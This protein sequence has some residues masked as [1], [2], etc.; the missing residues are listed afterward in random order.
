MHHIISDGWSINIFVNEFVAFY[1]ALRNGDAP[2]LA[3]LPIQYADYTNWQRE[4]LRDGEIDRQLDYWRRK[5]SG[6]LQMVEL[7]ADYPRTGEPALRG[8]RLTQTLSPELSQSLRD[9]SRR[10]GV[11]LYMTLLAAFNTLL[12]RSTN[13]HDVIVGTA[14]AG[15]NRAEIENLI[16]IFINMLVLRTDLSG[17]PTFLELLTRVRNVTVEAYAHQNVPF[18]RLV[19]ALQPA[20]VLSRSPFFQIAFGVDYQ[21]VRK[22]TLPDL[23]LSPISFPTELSR[24]DLTLWVFESDAD[25]TASWTFNTDLFTPETIAR[26]QARFETLLSSIVKEPETRLLALEIFSDDEKQQAENR[27][28]EWEESNVRKLMS[29]KRRPVKTFAGSAS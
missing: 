3:T 22:F 11:T 20:R 24:Y 13:Q 14:V 2:N 18:E 21:P 29:V 1:K 25:L 19:E 27:Q 5:L 4:R 28:Q 6:P 9:L 15:R 10:E 17:N 16:G 23:E 8:E 12:Y 7:P 26:L